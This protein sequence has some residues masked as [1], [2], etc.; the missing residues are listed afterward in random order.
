MT[1]VP[2]GPTRWDFSPDEWPDDD[3]VGIGAD[4]EP[5]TL[6]H[7]YRSA[8]FPMPTEPGGPMGWWSPLE[9]GV[10]RPDDLRVSRSLRKSARRFTITVDT[11]FAEVVE[12]CADPRREGGWIDDAIASAY[13]RLHELGWA[14]SIE[15]RTADGALAGGLYGVAIG[16]LFAGES[17]FHRVTDASK[18][19]L[20]G[21]VELIAADGAGPRLIDTQWRT[22]HLASLGVQAWSRD[23]Y[24]AVLPQVLDT[25]L[26]APWR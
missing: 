8:L 22:D 3:F 26:P 15:A 10:L 5:T 25:P 16:G 7:A 9:R 21:L 11:A 1:P 24:L 17:M 4:L 14:H 2:L 6:V 20:V 18:A 23:A 19:A 12:A 13:G